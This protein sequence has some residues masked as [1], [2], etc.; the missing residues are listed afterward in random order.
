VTVLEQGQVVRIAHLRG[1]YRVE[2]EH[3]SGR[4]S[5]RG[6]VTED[7]RD[8]MDT[9]RRVVSVDRVRR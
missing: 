8:R 1:H 4:V 3:P 6:P 7:G 5:V 2:F 9:R